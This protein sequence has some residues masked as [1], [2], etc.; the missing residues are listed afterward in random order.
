MPKLLLTH[1]AEFCAAYRLVNPAKSE[2]WNRETY[3]V[4]FSPHG[5]GHNYF[6]DVVVGGEVHPETGMVMD[7]NR[8][9]QLVNDQIVRSVDHLNLNEDVDFMRG[10][11]PTTENLILKFWER[12]CQKLPAEVELVELRLQESR[13]H[14]VTYRGPQS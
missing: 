5:H 13:D 12:L 1:R 2:A 8:L 6:L 11:I 9:A 14:S 10:V 3:G 7:L 4:C